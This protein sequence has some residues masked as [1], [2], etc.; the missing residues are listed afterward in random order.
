[1]RSSLKLKV[2]EM[3]ILINFCLLPIAFC[4]LL[5]GCK[6]EKEKVKEPDIASYPKIKAPSFNADSA[7]SFVDQ[8]V[9]F[10]PRVPNTI[11]HDKCGEFLINY[12]KQSNWEVKTQDFEAKTF[13]NKN[14]RLKNII[15]SY[16]PK[17]TKRILLAAHWDTRPFADQDTANKNKPIL[18]ANDGG[19]GVGVLLEIARTINASSVKPTIGIDI[20]LFDGEDY[21]ETE[22][23]NGPMKDTYCLGSQYW[24]ANLGDYSA[25]FGILLDMV[26]A[27]NAKFAKE[28]TSMQYGSEIV[29]MVWTTG[30]RLGFGNYFLDKKT[31]A[32]TDDHTYINSRAKIP[33]IDIIEFNTSGDSYFGDYW[34]THDDNMSVIDRNTLKAVGQ[35]LLEVLYNDYQALS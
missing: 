28:G 20:I 27:K 22:E 8:Q 3:R 7:Y 4:L 23:Y 10:G 2:K 13:D 19:S 30:N 6:C 33:T 21:G 18:G 31:A 25:F 12:L 15:A 24:A 32:I 17:A 34:H 5:T 35:T 1:M 11:E 14:L 29:N 26:G 9:A 16:N